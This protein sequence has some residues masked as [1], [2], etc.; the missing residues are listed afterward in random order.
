[1]PVACRA[2]AIGASAGGIH[3]LQTLL[4]ALPADFVVPILVVLH[5]DRRQPSLLAVVLRPRTP[6][7]V[8]PAEHDEPLLGGTVY[9]GVP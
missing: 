5:L 1:M 4:S 7:V 8:K 9:V 3:A 6:L 2:V